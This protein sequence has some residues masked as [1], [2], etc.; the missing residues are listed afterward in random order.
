MPGTSHL[1][2][3]HL[4]HPD[5]DGDSG[6][7]ELAASKDDPLLRYVIK[8]KGTYPE[9]ACNEFM[10]HKVAA[11][12]G[13][14]TQGVKLIAG[15]QNYRRAAAIRYVPG[16]QKF[17]LDGSSEENCRAYFEFEALYVILNEEDSHEYYLDGQGR[18]FKLDN[19]ASFNVEQATIMRFDGNPVGQLFVSDVSAPLHAVGYEWYGI[20]YKDFMERY[21]QAAVE[22]YLALIQ[23]FAALDE[24]ALYEVYDSLNKQYPMALGRYY[25]E[26]VRI[27]KETCRRFLGEIKGV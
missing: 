2:P 17:R 11:T 21:G 22:A 19:A 8:G 9:I 20:K 15:N 26:F 16:A 13:L 18:M 5:E 14:Y 23:R 12:L 4:L 6:A 3:F 7:M 27:R 25:D 10:Y 24:T 1:F